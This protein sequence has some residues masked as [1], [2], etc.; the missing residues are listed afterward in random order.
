MADLDV[1]GTFYKS[2]GRGKR[3]VVY[4]DSPFDDELRHCRTREDIF[5][6]WYERIHPVTGER[7]PQLYPSPTFARSFKDGD[8]VS[9]RLAIRP[10]VR[11]N[12]LKILDMSRVKSQRRS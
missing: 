6:Q 1:H 7:A 9:V 12:G 8:V 5:T 10:E 11:G 4:V 3:P 2:R